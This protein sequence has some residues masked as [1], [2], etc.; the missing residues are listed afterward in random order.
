MQAHNRGSIREF[1]RVFVSILLVTLL[2]PGPDWQAQAK[3]GPVSRPPVH[4]ALAGALPAIIVPIQL[5][6]STVP[7][8]GEAGV[9]LVYVTGSGFPSGTIPSTNV[10]VSFAATCG[11]GPLANAT[12]TGVQTLL[13]T[14]P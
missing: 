13:C 6:A 7:S 11:D 14:I 10:S 9:N 12:A 2:S 5:T 4:A 3:A 1:V 8:Q